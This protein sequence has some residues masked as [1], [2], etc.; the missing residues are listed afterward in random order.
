MKKYLKWISRSNPEMQLAIAGQNHEDFLLS[1]A[2]FSAKSVRDR[3]TI[4]QVAK[5][6]RRTEVKN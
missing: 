6:S 1:L 4:E 5:G 2:R 3:A